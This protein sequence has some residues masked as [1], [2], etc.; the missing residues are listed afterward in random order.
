MFNFTDKKL[1]SG[2]N[3][4]EN[5]CPKYAITMAEDDEGAIYPSVDPEKC[6]SCGLCEKV[7]PFRSNDLN[8]LRNN[9]KPLFFAAQLKNKQELQEVSSGGAFWGLV[10]YIISKKGLVYGVVQKN[11]DHI[12]H[13]RVDNLEDAKKLRRSKYFQSSTSGIYLEVKNDLNNGKTVLFSG[14][15]CQIAALKSFLG[16]KYENLYTCEV[17]CHG[18][19]V[20]NAWRSYRKE[21]EQKIGKRIVDLVFRDKSK[22]WSNNQYKITY[23]D[24]SSEYELSVKNPYHR[25]YLEG[26][27]YRPSCGSCPFSK[28]PKVADLTLADYWQY[29][30][31]LNEYCNM[32]VSL[33]SVN[34][35][36]G[37][38][39]LDK[40]REFLE[41]EKTSRI[42]ALKSC[43]HINNCPEENPQRND[44]ISHL[45]KYG[46]HSASDMFLNSIVDKNKNS[47]NYFLSKL[48]HKLS[49]T[50]ENNY[51][52]NKLTKA[53]VSLIER[54]S[55]KL[56]RYTNEDLDCI[57]DF[58]ESFIGR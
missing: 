8:L 40:S 1:C 24:G 41:I 23:E 10:Q 43:R 42:N 53:S 48:Y 14:V 39:L 33:V 4:C 12:N 37:L 51:F 15:P 44:F 18:V 26:L 47:S 58:Y 35:A 17:V 20:K 29:K 46:Y 28:I 36:H 55:R 16:K 50:I 32:G 30:G 7:C 25:G 13:I 54:I 9:E 22:G 21:K 31:S 11:V 52:A 6:I 27:F 45:L 3:A 2:C 56:C 49:E 5:I 38:S 19:P 57:R 34:N